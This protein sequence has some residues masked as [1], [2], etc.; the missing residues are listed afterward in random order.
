MKTQENSNLDNI[1]NINLDNLKHNLKV[2]KSKCPN[3]RIMAIIKANAYGHGS[4]M[5]AK[6]LNELGIKNFGVATLSEAL[7]IRKKI[8]GNILILNPILGEEMKKALKKD[9]IFTIS[10]KR[11]LVH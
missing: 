7:E 8:F 2:I 9:V 11:E 10:S 3:K 6:E 1:I 4:K 5:I